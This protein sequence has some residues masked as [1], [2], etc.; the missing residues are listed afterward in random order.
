MGDSHPK[1]DALRA[2]R[3]ARFGHL[4]ATTE[5]AKVKP[6]KAPAPK[7]AKKRRS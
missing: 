7:K 3:E 6:A 1:A 2:Q 5:P 4:Q